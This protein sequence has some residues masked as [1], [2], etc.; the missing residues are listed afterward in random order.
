MCSY[1]GCEDITVIGRLMAEHE[2]IRNAAG[3]LRRAAAT[4]GPDDV[5]ARVAALAGLLDPHVR[6]EERGLFDELHDDPEFAPHIDALCGEHVTLDAAVDE[7]R[8]GDLTGLD[9]LLRLLDAHIEREDN[10]IFPAAAT[11]L[12]GP[13]W[14]RITDRLTE[15]TTV[16]H[17]RHADLE[18]RGTP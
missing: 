15:S 12:D 18:P 7:V 9:A 13:A 17:D 11:A 8:R 16:A 1:C 2:A 6:D 14:D 5:A 10:G 4:G 3:D